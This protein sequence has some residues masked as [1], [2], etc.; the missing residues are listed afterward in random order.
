MRHA[1]SRPRLWMLA[2]G[3]CLLLISAVSQLAS[4]TASADDGPVSVAALAERVNLP[5]GVAGDHR[6][7]FIAEPLNGRVAIIDRSTG[8]PLAVLP[9]PPGGFLLPFEL[10]V[11]H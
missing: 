8:E 1:L 4:T 3:S 9:A 2:A 6:L 5:H 11:P 7:V 10:R